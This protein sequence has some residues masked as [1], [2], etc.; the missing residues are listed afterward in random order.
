MK[1]NWLTMKLNGYRAN[2]RNRWFLITKKILTLQEFLLFEYYLDLMDFDKSHGDKF[3]TFEA[4]LDEVAVVFNKKIDTVRLWHNALL[5]KHFIQIVN[6]RRH[7][8][9]IKSPL[10]YVIG[11]TTWGGEA[12]KYTKEE[13]NQTNEFIL[14]NLRFFQPKTGKIQPKSTDLTDI[15]TPKTEN[16]LSS[17]K[18][19]SIVNHKK[20]V[21]EQEVR[22]DE[23]YRDMLKEHDFSV[24]DMKLIDQGVKGEIVIE[25]GKMEKEIVE[26]YF[27][28]DWDTYKKHL[29][30]FT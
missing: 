19:D 23:E 20:I 9:I 26:I 22:S 24:S 2:H 4:Y 1:D 21:I 3:A 5:S 13:K 28:G 6:L 7:L 27:N 15:S 16:S 30:K 18:G 11:L 17:S 25:N 10:R 8:F 14:E 12:A 29:I